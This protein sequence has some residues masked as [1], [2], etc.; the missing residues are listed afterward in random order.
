[1]K[2]ERVVSVERRTAFKGYFEIGEYR[3]R[4]TLFAG[5]VGPEVRREIFERGHAATVLPYDPV[6]DAVV[7]IRQFRPG[8]HVAGR[9]AWI[10]EIVAG[11]IDAGETTE[12]VARREAR[13]EADLDILELLPMQTYLSS[14]GGTSETVTQF[15][16]RVD[17]SKAGGI[18]GLA[19]EGEDI[20]VRVFALA[21]ARAMLER[22]EIAS[23]SGLASML[24][25]L[26]H[27][28]TVRERWR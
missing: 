2:E 10:W 16:G 13:E 19:T 14:P 11:I 22:G 21:E 17:A 27:R 6:R 15:L 4:H 24:W 5:G 3:F 28:E 7:L 8:A 26:L 1:M 12:D 23:A 18:H 20:L 9:Q 25:L